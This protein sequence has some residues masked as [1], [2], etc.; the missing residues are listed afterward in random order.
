MVALMVLWGCMGEL[1]SV[2]AAEMLSTE[3][4]P[5]ARSLAVARGRNLDQVEVVVAGVTGSSRGPLQAL[6]D[7]VQALCLLHPSGLLVSAV[8]R[9]SLRSLLLWKS[10]TLRGHNGRAQPQAKAK[11]EKNPLVQQA[12]VTCLLQH[13]GDSVPTRASPQCLLTGHF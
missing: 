4:C 1:S 12:R 7:L 10:S 6:G 3:K 13:K 5:R 8:V 9:V 11:T 2:T